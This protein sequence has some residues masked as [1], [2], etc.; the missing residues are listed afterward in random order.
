MHSFI[1]HLSRSSISVVNN[2]KQI[3]KQLHALYLHGIIDS[4]NNLD[5]E[6]PQVFCSNPQL[7]AGQKQIGLFRALSS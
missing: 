2:C 6:G 7:R 1:K 3:D 5:W 4:Q